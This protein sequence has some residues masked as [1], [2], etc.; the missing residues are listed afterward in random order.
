MAFAFALSALGFR[1][2][3]KAALCSF[4]AAALR[5]INTRLGFP[6]TCLA[7]STWSACA[8]LSLGHIL[9][10]FLSFA[11]V[12]AIR[13][14]V[15]LALHSLKSLSTDL[16]LMGSMSEGAICSFGAAA[17]H[18]VATDL[19]LEP[20]GPGPLLPAV[21]KLVALSRPIASLTR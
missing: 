11:T 12:A 21:P 19:G 9:G 3:Q 7:L 13:L 5:K 18:V 15:A 14:V 17:F 16:K 4:V 6:V 2:V 10:H 20:N 1:I 8:L